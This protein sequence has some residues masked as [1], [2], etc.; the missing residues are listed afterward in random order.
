MGSGGRMDIMM[1]GFCGR[2]EKKKSLNV[3]DEFFLKDILR[4]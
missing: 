3:E 4:Y 1:G 2:G